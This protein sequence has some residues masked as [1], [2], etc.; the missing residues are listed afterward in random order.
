MT[1]TW[2][3]YEAG[4]EYKRRIGLYE[5]TRANERFYRGEQWTGQEGA[6]LPKPVFNLVKRIVDYLVCTVASGKYVLSYTDEN[7]PFNSRAV[8]VRAIKKA[9]EVL[10][11]NARYRWERCKMDSLVYSLLLDAALTGDGAVMCYWDTDAEGDRVF[12]GDIGV[13]RIDGVNLFAADMNRADIQSQEYIIVSGRASVESLRRE[14]KDNGATAAQLTRIT[15]DGDTSTAAGDAAYTELADGE[16]KATYLIK[17]WRE[18]GHVMFEKSTREHVIRQGKTDMRLYPVA[19]FNWMPV[20]NSFHG[21]SPVSGMLPNQRYI[22]MAY[23]LAMKH[24]IATAFSKVVYD[25][26]RIPEWSNEVGEA[27]AVVGAVNVSDAVSIVETG[28]MQDGYLELIDRAVSTTKELAGATETALGNASP[29]NTSAILALKETAR[30]TLEQ[31]TASLAACVEDVANIWADMMCAYYSDQR[32]V[33]FSRGGE[34]GAARL[35]LTVL[36]D[37]L[38]RARVDV[39][40]TA[41][42]SD[43]AAIGI[44][45]KLLDGGY[46]TAAQYTAH[47]PEGLLADRDL[48]ADGELGVKGGE[49]NG[50]KTTPDGDSQ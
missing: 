1:K 33:P 30:M 39:T 8:S 7:L 23:A 26:S 20:K 37:C 48:L 29:T 49:V 4:K 12:R 28:S 25:K 22:N 19:Y 46:I 6:E 18:D 44:L 16:G 43:S 34:E 45:D 38:V 5:K 15:A 31:V 42:Y 50:E 21:E 47:L 11:G 35:N 40:E 27:I 13:Q 32:L 14:A 10:T 24:M 3:Q 2:Q 36:R 17:F 41:R 9:L